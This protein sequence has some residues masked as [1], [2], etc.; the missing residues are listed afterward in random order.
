MAVDQVARL[1]GR[2]GAL[3]FR[4]LMQQQ[5]AHQML[6]PVRARSAIHMQSPGM[7]L[8]LSKMR[9]AKLLPLCL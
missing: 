8:M 1:I 7:L 3:D 5:V 4:A 9:T 6:K 2:K